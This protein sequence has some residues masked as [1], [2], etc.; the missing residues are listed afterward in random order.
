LLPQETYVAPSLSLLSAAPSGAGR[1]TRLTSYLI[2]AVIALLP[3]AWLAREAAR[4]AR[5]IA[6]WDDYDHVLGLIVAAQDRPADVPL[7]DLVLSENSGHRTILSRAIVLGTYH[8]LGR[9]DFDLF[10]VLGWTWILGACAILIAASPSPAGRMRLLAVLGFTLFT[11]QHFESFLWSGASID[12]FAV[13]M[14]ACASLSALDRW[15]GWRI[16]VAITCAIGGSITLAHGLAIWPIGLLMLARDR[17]WLGFAG[18]IVAALATGFLYFHDLNS[19][20][21]VPAA[22]LRLILPVLEFWLVLLGTPAALGVAALAPWLGAGLAAFTAWR[23]YRS[24]KH[25][26]DDASPSELAIILWALLALGL[27][28]SARATP[29]G[30]VVQSRYLILAALIWALHIAWA[31]GRMSAPARPLA[32]TWLALPLFALF[33]VL[34]N[35]SSADLAATFIEQRDRAALS[36][37][38]H[39]RDGMAKAALHPN[40]EAATRML[41]LC[42]A[43]GIYRFPEMCT[44]KAADA[45]RASDS[46]QWAIE[47]IGGDADS[48]TVSGWAA[49]PGEDVEP[50]DIEV[51]LLRDDATRAVTT[52][53]YRRD[54]LVAHYQEPGWRLAG[55]SVV[56]TRAALP[57]GQFQLGLRL[58]H[59]D[60]PRLTVTD[61]VVDLTGDAPTSK[62]GCVSFPDIGAPASPRDTAAVASGAIAYFVEEIEQGER[63]VVLRGWAGIP[64]AEMPE[65]SLSLILHAETGEQLVMPALQ[66]SRPDVAAAMQQ[67]QWR[68]PGFR[69]VLDQSRLPAGEFRVGFMIARARGAESILTDHFV[70]LKG[71]RTTEAATSAH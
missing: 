30:S 5:N 3:A 50:G 7:A 64:G 32:T 44:T 13:V 35:R 34:A 23:V 21:A 52:V 37:L 28:A 69:A 19:G 66:R 4:S 16:V 70:S 18:W 2:L 36:Y 53:Q 71:S 22:D 1:C 41:R 15:R 59:G 38:H 26:S 54:D 17:R 9:V 62:R 24:F 46:I 63:Y 25:A 58:Q 48:L 65:G 43:R 27:I 6:L 29:E 31:L 47:G 68:M 33:T 67:P 8:L 45:A 61:T 42:E 39:G 14:F 51:L 12:H 49:I 40:P 20:A 11:L 55:F 56:V 57:P 60:D 10:L